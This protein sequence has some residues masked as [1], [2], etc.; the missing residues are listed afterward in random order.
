MKLEG[1]RILIT[2]GSS[3]IG[4]AIAQALLVKGATIAIT[5]RRLAGSRPPRRARSK[6]G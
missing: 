3:G 5:G 4:F 2:G 6:R 1:K